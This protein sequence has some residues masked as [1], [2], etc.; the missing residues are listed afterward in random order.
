ML[1][2]SA[3]FIASFLGSGHCVAMCGGLIAAGARSAV[4]IVIYHA[5]R[6]F[7]YLLLGAFF[8]ALGES[9]QIYFSGTV[10]WIVAIVMGLSF[11]LLG[12]STWRGKVYLPVPRPLQ[13]FA[14]SLSTAVLQRSGRKSANVYAGLLGAF[15]IFLPCGW[16]YAF[17]LASTASGSSAGGAAAMFFFWLGTLP[18]LTVLPWLFQRFLGPLKKWSPQISALILMTVGFMSIAAKFM[19]AHHGA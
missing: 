16:L 18:A 5:G 2:P 10:S 7:A 3:V 14:V 15:S 17:A 8:G 6:L 13:A 9:A 12:I 1:I 4:N 19:H 11:I